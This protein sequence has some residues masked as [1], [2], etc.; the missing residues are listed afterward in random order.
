[1]KKGQLL[2]W[3]DLYLPCD[4]SEN[5]T[6]T[7][8][9]TEVHPVWARN[10]SGS[11]TYQVSQAM[12]QNKVS[13]GCGNGM[14]TAQIK[15]LDDEV[16]KRAFAEA[17]AK[18]ERMEKQPGALKKAG[19]VG[20][21]FKTILSLG[22]AMADLDPTGSAKIVFS[23]CT[24]AWERLE[25]QDQQDADLNELAKSLARM[26][27]SVDS[28]KD[29]ADDNLRETVMDMLNLVEDVS[30]FILNFRP[31]SSFE[32]AWRGATSSDVD[33]KTQEYIARFKSL[34]REFDRR[35]G[36]QSLRAVEIERMNAKLREL[37]P[38]DLAGYDPDRQCIPGTRVGVIDELA[39]W[40]E[41]PD[42]GPRLAWVHGLAGLGKSSIAASVSRRL[43]E[44]R[45]LACSFFCKRDNPELR[46]PRR[47]LTTIVYGL[48]V[49]WEAYREAVVA[50]I[51]EDPEISSKHLRPLYDSLVTRP[52]QKLVGAKQPIG[53]LV[54]VVDALDECGDIITRRQLLGCLRN[55]SQ[56]V[57]ALKI[58][59][60]SR[61][62]MDIREFFGSIDATCF[63]RY[64]LLGY[65]AS[66]DIRIFV[67]DYF[68]DL[69]YTEDW[70]NDAIERLSVCSSGLFIWARTA[71]KFIL[72]G[73]DR[74]KRLKQVLANP[75]LNDIDTLY[76]TAIKASIQ[77]DTEDNM[78][79]VLGCLGAIVA[80]SARTPLSIP[81]LAMLLH[82][83]IP[84][85]VL[86]RVV[87]S[88][89]S[90]LYVDQKL[91]GAIRISHP[92]FMDYIIA[93]S[94]SKELCVN[95]EQHNTILADCCLQVMASNLKFN[96]CGLETS[97]L[98]NSDV[99]DLDARVREAIHPHLNY[100]CLYWSSHVAEARLDTLET[101]LRHFLFGPELVYWLEALSLL[102]KLNV[103]PGGLL[104]LVAYC[105]S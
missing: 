15:F 32:R 40:A 13:I 66:D 104:K 84:R 20:D 30:L 48:A 25:R 101:S 35:V 80:T 11:A 52:L 94:R 4:V 27:P 7:F 105:S 85:G 9:I 75:K 3:S 74:H 54:V 103:A 91:D 26:I 96:I 5:S 102:G 33:E 50:V 97:E 49:R 18:V 12:N 37:K 67:R 58:I 56:I 68:S 24:K 90:V 59:A 31:R 98:P 14:F 46:D 63:T 38:A 82:G 93:P 16:V 39:T 44:R 60:T 99:P 65:D 28:V 36:V 10:R 95:L 17:V 29:L 79:Y 88:L 45:V 34:S 61:P 51:R 76:T 23:V 86:E 64:D 42:D 69:E 53:A 83:R 100:S 73:Y 43:D 87:A 62:D 1:M 78:N 21:A 77:D 92:S 81:N 57:P 70:P 19:G 71:C 72:D 8:Q 41:N 47:V 55:M 22:N 2:S 6:I 89:S